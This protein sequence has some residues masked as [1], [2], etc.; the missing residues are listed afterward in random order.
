[1]HLIRQR[2]ATSPELSHCDCQFCPVLSFFKFATEPAWAEW[3]MH[4]IGPIHSPDK[5]EHIPL[6]L[7]RLP[8][9]PLQ[10]CT[11]LRMSFLLMYTAA[12]DRQ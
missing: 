9:T 11:P 7:V 5:S 3:Q 12:W 4:M 6:H 8:W 10:E 2:R 1:M